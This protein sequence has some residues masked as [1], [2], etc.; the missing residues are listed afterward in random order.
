M[1]MKALEFNVTPNPIS[2]STLKVEKASLDENT[3]GTDLH[4]FLNK[5]TG[6]D[7]YDLSDQEMFECLEKALDYWKYTDSKKMLKERAK[8]WTIIKLLNG[9]DFGEGAYDDEVAEIKAIRK[10]RTN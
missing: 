5:F 7:F 3:L 8:C 1:E 9:D 6:Y 2:T 10:A 4:Q